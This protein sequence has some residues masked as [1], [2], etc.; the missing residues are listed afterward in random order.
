MGWPPSGNPSFAETNPMGCYRTATAARCKAPC[1][2]DDLG[3]PGYKRIAAMASAHFAQRI[4][5][6]LGL[7]RFRISTMLLLMAT[8]AVA[9]AWRRDHNALVAQIERMQNPGPRWGVHEAT[10]PPNTPGYGDI[11]TAWAS[12]SPDDQQ[13]W[14]QL[15]FSVEV[16]PVAIRIHETYNPGAVVKIARVGILGIEETLWEGVDPTTPGAAGGVSTFAVSTRKPTSRIKIYLD[17]PAVSGWNEIDA[18]GLVD[19]N[20]EATWASKASAS[21]SY[22]PTE[23]AMSG[24]YSASEFV[25]PITADGSFPQ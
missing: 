14:L 25:A 15:D 6:L 19:A 16:I 2:G 1:P 17:S 22:G 8:V 21:S 5:S 12:K 13:E 18:V 10:G 7:V 3:E 11:A 20:G 23:S 4:R 24:Y 9:L